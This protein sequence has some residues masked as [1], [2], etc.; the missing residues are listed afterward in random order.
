MWPKLASQTF[1]TVGNGH[2]RIYGTSSV[3]VGIGSNTFT[4]ITVTANDVGKYFYSWQPGVAGAV[5]FG[6]VTNVLA[7]VAT[8][9]GTTP[10]VAITNGSFILGTA[11][12][13]SLQNIVDWSMYAG[14]TPGLRARQAVDISPG[15]FILN[16]TW[17]AGYGIVYPPTGPQISHFTNCT[18]D[19]GTPPFAGDEEFNGA[20]VIATFSDSPAINVQGQFYGEIR[21]LGVFGPNASWIITKGLGNFTGPIDTTIDDTVLANWWDPALA[22]TGT[23]RYAPDCGICLDGYSGTQ[24]SPSYPAVTYPS[25]MGTPGQY[26]KIQSSQLA[27]NRISFTGFWTGLA[28]HP[29]GFESQGD[30]TNLGHCTMAY[31]AVC[32]S[33]GDVQGRNLDVQG[34]EWQSFHTYLCNTLIGNQNGYIQGSTKNAGFVQGIQLFDCP[35]DAAN[36][37]H[38]FDCCSVE[39]VWRIGNWGSNVSTT[40]GHNLTLSNLDWTN[41]SQNDTRGYPNSLIYLGVASTCTI[42]GGQMEMIKPQLF[43][44]PPNN[45]SLTNLVIFPT[46]VVTHEYQYLASNYLTGG[47]LFNIGAARVPASFRPDK[48]SV[49]NT[50]YFNVD[51]GDVSSFVQGETAFGS[52]TTP[53]HYAAKWVTPVNDA[54]YRVPST[55]QPYN[56]AKTNATYIQSIS[57]TGRELT[58]TFKAAWT[59]AMLAGY[60]PSNGDIIFDDHDACFYCVHSVVGQIVTATLQNGYRFLN[61]TYTYFAPF[62]S[63]VGT[64]WF[65]NTRVYC[66]SDFIMGDITAGSADIDNVSTIGQQIGSI[67]TSY[68]QVGDFFGDGTDP[69]GTAGPFGLF[70]LGSSI[71]AINPGTTYGKKVTLS[72]PALANVGTIAREPLLAWIRPAPANV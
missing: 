29:S 6:T 2:A 47:I 17:Q 28:I 8:Y 50:R 4:G 62:S 21:N 64:F 68:L 67:G 15:L 26:N 59:A 60:G 22:S 43:D 56:L 70:P 40:V 55:L 63:T 31:N 41:S 11:E 35:N 3:V 61:S 24:P 19:G 9:S 14:G 58:L 72:N 27:L 42:M 13:A 51:T 38:T 12:T 39:A 36:F 65:H 57:R 16:K 46:D 25:Y 33:A 37:A 45:Y 52:R 5:A 48:F 10:T 49:K 71:V 53:V 20:G 18:I 66:P 32:I 34:G 7:G 23:S 44:G 1:G 54:V 30:F 69:S